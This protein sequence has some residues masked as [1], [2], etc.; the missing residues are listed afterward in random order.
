[1]K[2]VLAIVAVLALISMPSVA[3]G[4]VQPIP[5]VQAR[6]SWVALDSVIV[7]GIG[8]TFDSS[9]YASVTA[10]VQNVNCT[11]VITS[12]SIRTGPAAPIAGGA[13]EY[14]V[15]TMLM[16][17]NSTQTYEFTRLQKYSA[18]F[19]VVFGAGC[20]VT[21]TLIGN[22]FAQTVYA[23]GIDINDGYY[24]GRP[25]VAGGLCPAGFSTCTNDLTKALRADGLGR[26][27]VVGGGSGTGLSD[28][29]Q[30]G[31]T[32]SFQVP[33]T[34][35]LAAS[36]SCPVALVASACYQVT[37]TVDAYVRTGAGVPVAVV[38]DT[39][40][41]AKVIMRPVCL[42]AAENAMAFIS[43]SAGTCYVSRMNLVP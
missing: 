1:M 25:V 7:G 12:F 4:Q 23:Q 16:N 17:T 32:Y 21:V 3:G 36:T 28:V 30:Y 38:T 24:S 5:V 39:P 42:P 15:A 13:G 40:L 18:T 43:A 35:A 10:V 11:S 14:L 27:T 19:L 2:T 31:A 26:L 34:C 22:P 8:T 9:G 6:D 20:T 29:A 33:T 37:C 41:Y